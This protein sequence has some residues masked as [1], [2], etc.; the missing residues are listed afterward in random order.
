MAM[1]LDG[2]SETAERLISLLRPYTPFADAIVRRQAERAGIPL[3]LVTREHL[4]RLTPMIV[5]AVQTFVDPADLVEIKWQLA[6]YS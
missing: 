1:A 3:H 6:R 5:L 2:P 4:A